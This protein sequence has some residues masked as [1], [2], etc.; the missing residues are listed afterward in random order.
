MLDELHPSRAPHID[1]REQEE[2]NHV[3][4]M[5]VPGGG[6]EAEML[7]RL[8]MT[9]ERAEQADGQEDGADDDMKAM[10]AGRHEEGRAVDVAAIVA[11]EGE[12]GVG[13]FIGLDRSEER[14]QEDGADEAPFEAPAVV[15]EESVMRP[16]D[17]CS[18][19]QQDERIDERQVP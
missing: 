7:R 12:G 1:A 14:A 5:P 6:L 10:E 9:G 19:G 15:V 16:G 17:G 11:A 2:P 4:E 3:D 8:E 13:I 18:G